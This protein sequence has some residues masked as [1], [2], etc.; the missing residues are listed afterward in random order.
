MS[1]VLTCSFKANCVGTSSVLS[2]IVTVVGVCMMVGVCM[3]GFLLLFFIFLGTINILCLFILNVRNIAFFVALLNILICY[4]RQHFMIFSNYH[5]LKIMW[6][7]Q[8]AL[9]ILFFIYFFHLFL[10]SSNVFIKPDHHKDKH[11]CLFFN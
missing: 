11:S 1:I 4:A 3:K 8:L 9:R 6:R 2:K 10:N 7:W 5:Y